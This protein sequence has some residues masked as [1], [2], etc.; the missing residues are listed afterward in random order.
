MTAGGD[1][2]GVEWSWSGLV[3]EASLVRGVVWQLLTSGSCVGGGGGGVCSKL[4]NAGGCW[5]VWRHRQS[6]RVDRHVNPGGGG[7]VDRAIMAE[8]LSK[9]LS[10]LRYL[11]L[12]DGSNGGY[13][14]AQS[15]VHRG[16]WR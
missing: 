12:S 5:A 10:K 16:A 1:G 8:G 7:N 14:C 15:Q 2:E 9:L 4:M 6:S 13:Q 3:E 11:L